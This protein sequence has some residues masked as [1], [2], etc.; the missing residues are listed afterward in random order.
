MSQVL[1]VTAFVHVNVLPMNTNRVL[2]D[3]TVLVRSERILETGA[4]ATMRVP[5]GARVIDGHRTVNEP[6]D[7]V[8][9]LRALFTKAGLRDDRL[10]LVSQDGAAHS[11][12]WWA[13][14][15]PGALAFLF[16]ARTATP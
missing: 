3:H 6:V 5:S 15:L 13:Q 7:D 1:S 14:R 9:K 8:E 10:R 4:A 11:E 12:K 2:R 16:P